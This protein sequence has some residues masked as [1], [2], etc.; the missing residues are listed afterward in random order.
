MSLKRQKLH[1]PFASA[2]VLCR[3]APWDSFWD[4][5][6]SF[7]GYYEVAQENWSKVRPNRLLKQVHCCQARGG[8]SFAWLLAFKK[9]FVPPVSRV[10]RLF[11]IYAPDSP[12]AYKTNYATD[13]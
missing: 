7:L 8:F 6:I 13:R 4:A 9:S 11:Y 2:S 5:I 1:F 10:V 12:R 3:I